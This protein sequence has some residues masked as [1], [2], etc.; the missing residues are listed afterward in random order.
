MH[1]TN[2]MTDGGTTTTKPSNHTDRIQSHH[3]RTHTTVNHR[4]IFLLSYQS[5]AHMMC[6]YALSSHPLFNYF[7]SWCEYSAD[8]CL[9][10]HP[11][12]LSRPHTHIPIVVFTSMCVT[13]MVHTHTHTQHTHTHSHK[14]MFYKTVSSWNGIE[15][16][17]ETHTYIHMHACV[18]VC[19]DRGAHPS[20]SPTLSTIIHSPFDVSTTVVIVLFFTC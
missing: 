5:Y 15:T 11:H 10:P 2:A 4:L 19:M 3:I 12:T 14:Y 8:V 1:A 18:Y 7:G 13:A 6:T 20:S 9:S 16:S 17:H